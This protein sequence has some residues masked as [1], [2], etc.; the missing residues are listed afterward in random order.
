MEKYPTQNHAQTRADNLR[1]EADHLANVQISW[2]LRTG[3][4]IT[5]SAYNP[6]VATK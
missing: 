4:G 2:A 5:A 1:Q 3:M 6:K